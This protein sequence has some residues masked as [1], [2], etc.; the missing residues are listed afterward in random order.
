M[1]EIT[2]YYVAEQLDILLR[3]PQGGNLLRLRPAALRNHLLYDQP[4]VVDAIAELGGEMPDSATRDDVFKIH[5][6]LKLVR[7]FTSSEV[8][9]RRAARALRWLHYTA[10]E[11]WAD[12]LQRQCYWT[13]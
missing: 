9:I 13:H 3:M 10:G 8:P 12:C 6:A 11:D 5:D 7:D 1:T 2:D 4:W